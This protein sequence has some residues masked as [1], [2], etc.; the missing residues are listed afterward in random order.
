MD[1]FIYLFP[2]TILIAVIGIV[3]L[4]W[5]IYSGQYDDLKGDT[6][7]FIIQSERGDRD[8]KSKIQ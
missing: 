6:E 5:A 3:A 1:V 8:E 7:R 2:I 4:I